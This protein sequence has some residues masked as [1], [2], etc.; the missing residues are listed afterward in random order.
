MRIE[1]A[2]AVIELE[3]A[4]RRQ[5][6]EARDRSAPGSRPAG[7]VSV[8][9]VAPQIAHHTA[10]R[11]FPIGKKNGGN[12]YDCSP[13]CTL[14]FYKILIGKIR[15][16]LLSRRT[17][18]QYPGIDLSAHEYSDRNFWRYS[19]S[20]NGKPRLQRSLPK[21]LRAGSAVLENTGISKPV[22][23][24]TP[25]ETISP[26]SS[27]QPFHIVV[28]QRNERNA[29]CHR[30][31]R[32]LRKRTEAAKSEVMGWSIGSAIRAAKSSAVGQGVFDLSRRPSLPDTASG[33]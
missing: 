2:A 18:A 3:L 32:R 26:F 11:T 12:R 6:S 28:G 25:R 4:R 23:A 33:C 5:A 31:H 29:F 27:I 30:D 7:T 16:A 15:I 8:E 14:L 22:T 21:P 1:E 19:A 24:F 10:K 20:R 17:P 13:G 9:R